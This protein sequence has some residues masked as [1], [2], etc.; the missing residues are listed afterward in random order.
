M[1]ILT[2]KKNETIKITDDAQKLL[3]EI[4]I[5]DIRGC[6][7]IVVGISAPKEITILRGEVIDKRTKEVVHG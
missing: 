3:A 7:T 2:R 5:K 4:V 1:L 6:T